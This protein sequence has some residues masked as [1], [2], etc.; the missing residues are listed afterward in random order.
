M[1]YR[2]VIREERDRAV[3]Q[4]QKLKKKII[5]SIIILVAISGSLWALI[6]TVGF[7]LS[8]GGK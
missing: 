6:A 5:D 4:Q 2:K 8:L 3:Y 7:M 1:S